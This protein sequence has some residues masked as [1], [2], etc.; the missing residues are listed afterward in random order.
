MNINE[1][2]LCV[3]F[4]GYCWQSERFRAV[5]WMAYNLYERL[6]QAKIRRTRYT[7]IVR[8]PSKRVTFVFVGHAA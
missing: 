5:R 2:A 6:P 4:S 8:S 1:I 3:Q 7:W